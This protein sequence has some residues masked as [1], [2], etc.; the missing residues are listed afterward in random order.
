MAP[1]RPT[2]REHLQQVVPAARGAGLDYVSG[3]LV[4]SG[5]EL[6]QLRGGA[7]TA[8]VGRKAGAEHIG[9]QMQIV[10]AADRAG[11]TGRAAHVASRPDEL[12]VSIANL[13]LAEAATAE[14]VDQMAAREAVVDDPISSQQADVERHGR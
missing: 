8:A 14:L 13:V 6:G 5:V 10:L 1:W 9:D 2:D 3:E 11:D 12:G 4:G 7:D